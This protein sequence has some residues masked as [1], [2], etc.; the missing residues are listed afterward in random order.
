MVGHNWGAEHAARWIWLHG[1]AFAGRARRVARPRRSAAS[2]SGRVLTP[3]I[4][5][6][7][8]Q[9][10]GARTRA[11]RAAARARRRDARRAAGSSCPARVVEARSPA[12]QTVAWPYADP[13]G[14]E[15]HSLNCSIAEV[16]VRARRT[17]SC[18]PPHG[19]VYELGVA[20]R[21][22]GVALQPFPDG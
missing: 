4:A 3:W 22:H 8:L 19:G 1:V 16:T 14:G 13:G 11:R 10:G 20:P 9:A 2:A 12:G 5:N 7:A 21:R 17:A 6:G 15:H 18:A